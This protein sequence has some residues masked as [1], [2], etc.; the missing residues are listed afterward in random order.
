MYVLAAKNNANIKNNL[1]IDLNNAQKNKNKNKS[2][3]DINIISTF[4]LTVL[5]TLPIEQRTRASLLF[6]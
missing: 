6:N 1:T 2:V 3:V 5:A 4:A